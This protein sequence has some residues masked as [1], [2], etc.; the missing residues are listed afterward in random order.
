MFS[1]SKEL[2]VILCSAALLLNAG[3]SL[4]QE[5]HNHGHAH[6]GL[7]S[8]QLTLN[9]GKKWESDGNLRQGMS[10]IRDALN[11]DLHA[12]HMGKATA[13]QYQALAKKI[14]VQ[15]EF[16][17]NNCKLEPK[18]DEMLHLV[19]AD[20][21]AGSE[22]M[23]QDLGKAREGAGR[24]AQAL[25]SYGAHFAHPGWDKAKHAH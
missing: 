2:A 22:A 17:M 7:E 19:L 4:A 8:A 16:M 9:D 3:A 15:I 24:I 11:A 12:I 25:Q 21:V 20:I 13:D 1:S 23:K 14:D 5:Q 6:Y 10:R 18:A